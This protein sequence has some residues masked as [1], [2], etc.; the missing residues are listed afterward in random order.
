MS[1]Q[2]TNLKIGIIGGGVLGSAIKQY[3]KNAKI[4]DINPERSLNALEEVMVQDFVFICVSTPTGD[5]EGGI[6]LSFINDVFEKLRPGP[7][8]ILKSTVVPNT[9]QRIQD[10]YPMLGLVYSPEFLTEKFATEDFAFPDKNIIGYTKQSRDL[11]AKVARI[12]PT[13][14]TIMMSSTEAEMVKYAI[15]SYYA[16]KVIFANEL[17][18]FCEKLD[19]NYNA[20]HRGIVADKRIND[21]H[22]KIIHGNYRG[23]GGACLPKDSAAIIK[24][25]KEFGVDLGL[26]R[27][28][29]E[30]NKKFNKIKLREEI[31]H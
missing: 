6:D 30:S 23:F 12:L 1:E 14:N 5:S 2:K 22:F 16:M 21:S 7:V 11:A 13:S 18:E 31:C 4:Y 20:V 8:Y 3:Y 26:I 17:F 29:I 24:K 28:A 15:N 10:D 27:A 25:A 9:T 19:I